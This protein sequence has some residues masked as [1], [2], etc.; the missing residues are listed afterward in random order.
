MKICSVNFQ[1]FAQLRTHDIFYYLY[2]IFNFTHIF[3]ESSPI[4][5]N[6]SSNHP[7]SNATYPNIISIKISISSPSLH[8]HRI[9]KDLLIPV[10]IERSEYNVSNAIENRIKP[11]RGV[12]RFRNPIYRPNLI[13]LIW[14]SIY[15]NSWSC[16]PV[17][18]SKGRVKGSGGKETLSWPL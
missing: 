9:N 5:S 10:S 2:T 1:I 18:K 16:G 6:A 8:F 4:L 13:R 12:K 7:L 3:I 14:P 15:D 11:R 17:I